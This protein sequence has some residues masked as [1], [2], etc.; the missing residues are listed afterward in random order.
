V[1]RIIAALKPLGAPIIYFAND[2]ATHLEDAAK[3]GADALAIDWRL[4][5]VQARARVGPEITLQGNLD[6]CALFADVGEIERRVAAILEG[7]R[8][9]RHVFNL[10]HGILPPTDPAKATALVEMV[11]RL[12]ATTAPAR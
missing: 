10:G 8:G 6:P 11:H 4:P 12:G 1:A 5:L 7:A 9:T 2:G 3:L